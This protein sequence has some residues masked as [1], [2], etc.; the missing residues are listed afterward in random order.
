M[1]AAAGAEVNIFVDFV[2]RGSEVTVGTLSVHFWTSFRHEIKLCFGLA[3]GCGERLK[4][5]AVWS[6]AVAAAA[7]AEECIFFDFFSD[8][9]RSHVR[10]FR[11]AFSHVVSARLENVFGLAKRGVAKG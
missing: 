5:A 11:R 3:K 9:F 10:Q 4:A 8:G 7:G 1:A 6:P 2:A